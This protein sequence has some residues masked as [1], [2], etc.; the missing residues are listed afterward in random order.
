MCVGR[1][2][3]CIIRINLAQQRLKQVVSSMNVANGIDAHA[4]R[5]PRTIKRAGWCNFPEQTTQHCARHIG[6]VERGGKALP[7]VPAAMA[8]RFGE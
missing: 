8:D 2:A 5:H 7:L 1:T 4:I 3:C 6:A